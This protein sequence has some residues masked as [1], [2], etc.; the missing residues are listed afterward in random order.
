MMENIPV[1]ISANDAAG[2]C[3]GSQKFEVSVSSDTIIKSATYTN[4]SYAPSYTGSEIKPP[5]MTLET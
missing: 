4:S 1:E 5:K 2:T 3:T